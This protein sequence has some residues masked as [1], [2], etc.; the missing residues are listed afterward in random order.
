M[1]TLAP[2]ADHRPNGQYGIPADNPFVGRDGADEI[3][4]Y[5]FRNPYRMSLDRRTGALVAGDVGQNDIEEVD[6]VRPGQNY[7]WPIK[8]GTF[9]FDNNG[10]APGKQDDDD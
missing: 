2:P 10:A 8:E 1:A 6:V 5:G 7:G 3:W 9:T 4:A